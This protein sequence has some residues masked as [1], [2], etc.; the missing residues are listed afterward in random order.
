MH[1][2][3]HVRMDV[4]LEVVDMDVCIKMDVRVDVSEDICGHIY[5]YMCVHATRNGCICVYV[6]VA[7]V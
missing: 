2:E 4:V 7:I 6:Y 3:A 5:I 1:N